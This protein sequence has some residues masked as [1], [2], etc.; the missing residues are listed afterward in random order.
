MDNRSGIHDL[1]TGAS[2]ATHTR[3]SSATASVQG[4][5]HHGHPTAMHHA[6]QA[7]KPKGTAHMLL[8]SRL[9]TS[10]L[11]LLPT[12]LNSSERRPPNRPVVIDAY[13]CAKER[14]TAI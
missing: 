8:K 6:A 12:T 1:M 11:I 14:F 5:A 9:R 10:L 4:R 2:G 13:K 3:R 7:L